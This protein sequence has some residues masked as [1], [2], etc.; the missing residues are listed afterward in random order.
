MSDVATMERKRPGEESKSERVLERLGDELFRLFC[1]LE[2]SSDLLVN[3][4]IQEE[5][6]NPL[7]TEGVGYCVRSIGNAVHQCY[8]AARDWEMWKL[9]E[10]GLSTVDTALQDDR[11]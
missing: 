4:G 9:P 10:E 2:A 11:A 5:G 3:R 1:W 8:L 6:L 7:Q